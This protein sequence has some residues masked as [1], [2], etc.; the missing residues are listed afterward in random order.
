[1]VISDASSIT[2]PLKRLDDLEIEADNI[3]LM[4][5]DVEGYEKFVIEGAANIL[6]KVQCVYFESMAK[7]TL[8]YGYKPEELL[9]FLIRHGFE[10]LEL[11]NNNVRLINPKQYTNSS[12]DLIAVR[13]SR[14]FLA[15][16]DF[17]FS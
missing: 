1:M 13:D 2:V 16:T 6:S 15:R 14:A 5:I 17:Q 9:T 8:R 12:D 11:R 7:N 10:I 4:K 3:S